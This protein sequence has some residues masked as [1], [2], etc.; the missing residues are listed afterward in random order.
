[1]FLGYVPN[2]K[3]YK[4]YDL[5][6]HKVLVSRDVHFYEDQFT[7]RNIVPED[8]TNPLPNIIEEHSSYPSHLQD[9]QHNGSEI[10][11]PDIDVVPTETEPATPISNPPT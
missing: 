3:G 11:V 8:N 6:S 10:A 1:M 4:V 7:Y 2:C 5:Q 9:T